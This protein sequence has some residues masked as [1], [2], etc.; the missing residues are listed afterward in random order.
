MLGMINR[1]IE[2][3]RKD[4]IVKLYKSLVRPLVEYCTPAW[5]P[6]YEKDKILIERV[7]HRFTRVI[8]GLK[9]LPYRK[10]TSIGALE[11]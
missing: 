8:P 6:H 4:I 9:K 5:S 1:T 2:F 3:K 11:F 7:Q 10:K